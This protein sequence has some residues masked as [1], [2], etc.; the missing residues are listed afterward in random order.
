MDQ[1]H[2]EKPQALLVAVV[3]AITLRP[4]QPGRGYILLKLQAEEVEVEKAAV[5][6]IVFS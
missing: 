6:L 1:G 2:S 5:C 4:L 3:V